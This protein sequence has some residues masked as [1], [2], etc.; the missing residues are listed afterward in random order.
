MLPGT[1]RNT[2]QQL[3][4][5]LV[6]S[7]HF[8]FVDLGEQRRVVVE[9]GVGQEPRTFVPYLLFRFGCSASVLTR[10]RPPFTKV[11]ARRKR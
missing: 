6:A 5:P 3:Y 9:N 4:R 10:K 11:T 8:L 2:P 7:S 1:G